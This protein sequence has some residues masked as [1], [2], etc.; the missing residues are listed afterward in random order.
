MQLY[1]KTI[2]GSR[3]EWKDVTCECS[4]NIGLNAKSRLEI[5]NGPS[6]CPYPLKENRE[7]NYDPYMGKRFKTINLKFSDD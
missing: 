3:R 6:A 7:N 5:K 2:S 1:S 4:I